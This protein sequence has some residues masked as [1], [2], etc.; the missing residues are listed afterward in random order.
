MDNT[1]LLYYTSS[2]YGYGVAAKKRNASVSKNIFAINIP[3]P[4]HVKK[5]DNVIDINIEFYHL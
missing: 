5:R 2:D 4:P 1:S 3:L